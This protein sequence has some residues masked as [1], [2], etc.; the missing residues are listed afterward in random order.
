[1]KEEMMKSLKPRFAGV[2]ENTL[3]SIATLLDP[4]FKD[5]FFGSNITKTTVKEM[6]EEVQKLLT[7]TDSTHSSQNIHHHC[8]QQSFLYPNVQRKTLSLQYFQK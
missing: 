5:R 1:M 4:C 8:S 6:L 2:E 7:M 3:L